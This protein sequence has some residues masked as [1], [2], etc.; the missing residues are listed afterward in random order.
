MSWTDLFINSLQ[1]WEE[2]CI[3]KN[4]ELKDIIFELG[5]TI[6]QKDALDKLELQDLKERINELVNREGIKECFLIESLITETTNI[7]KKDINKLG[8]QISKN[9]RHLKLAQEKNLSIDLIEKKLEELKDIKHI[10]TAERQIDI[11][12]VIINKNFA[13]TI[14]RKLADDQSEKENEEIIKNLEQLVN[15]YPK[16]TTLG[17][18]REKSKNK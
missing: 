12:N 4:K 18:I 10:Y 8:E 7:L 13:L 11:W 2:Q 5:Y 6:G 17:E 1:E 15:V 9:E 16:G 14:K 3:D